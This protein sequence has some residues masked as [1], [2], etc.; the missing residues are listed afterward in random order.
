MQSDVSP[1]GVKEPV[2]GIGMHRTG[3]RSLC[4]YLNLLGYRALHWP[5]QYEN[6]LGRHIR[7]NGDRMLVLLDPIFQEYDAFADVPFPGL[8]R[9]L[10]RRFTQARFILTTRSAESW[11][12]SLVR[13]WKLETRPFH[14]LNPGEE[15]QYRLYEPNEKNEAR[16]DDKAIFIAKF[17]YHNA[18]VKAHFAGNEHKLL[19]V[20]LDDPEKNAK[21]SAFLDKAV[22]PY[23]CIND[24]RVILTRTTG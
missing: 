22:K 2:F 3:T 18:A 8:Y 17:L 12:R 21:I 11:W 10:E 24:A 6:E 9:E 13:H 20:D 16:L 7:E 5:E 1:A 4:A 14:R 19:V 15:I 23:P